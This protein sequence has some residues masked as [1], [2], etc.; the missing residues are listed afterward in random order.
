MSLLKLPLFFLILTGWFS[1][2]FVLAFIPSDVTINEI[3]W[4]GT[5]VSPNDE[6]IELYNNAD[7]PINL[8]GWVLIAV[9]GSP[10]INLTGTIPANGYYLLERTDDNSVP[11]ISADQ[12]YT[13]AFKN[14]GENLELYD[15]SEKL[16]D[17]V[18]CSS[19]WFTGDNETKQTMERKDPGL[20]GNR[21]EAWQTS[22]SSKGTPGA[23]NSIVTKPLLQ[24]TTSDIKT[25][26]PP[27]KGSQEE[28]GTLTLLIAAAL[29]IF[30]GIIILTLKKKLRTKDNDQG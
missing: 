10:E 25:E 21:P 7:L 6:W 12:I 17:S 13:G 16:A 19:G 2:N 18:D 20:S 11:E 4:M 8:E 3:A 14:S 22:Q 26:L 30:S 5:D 9:D 27:V 29:A 24:E 28:P 15:S 23:K 1:V